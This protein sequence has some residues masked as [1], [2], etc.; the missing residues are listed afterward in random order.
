L[1]ALCKAFWLKGLLCFVAGHRVYRLG[2]YRRPDNGRPHCGRDR[3]EPRLC[4]TR[5]RSPRCEPEPLRFIGVRGAA[6]LAGSA[7]RHEDHTG[8]TAGLRGKIAQR[9]TV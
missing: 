1:D 3:P 4:W 7:D 8:R 5:D 2:Q 6:A 9:A